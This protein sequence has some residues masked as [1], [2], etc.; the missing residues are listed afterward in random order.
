M[1]DKVLLDAAEGLLNAIDGGTPLDMVQ[2]NSLQAIAACLL[3]IA[4]SKDE[5]IQVVANPKLADKQIFDDA[6][7]SILDRTNGTTV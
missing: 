4:R 7:A 5:R 6:V 2:A 1:Q 3:V